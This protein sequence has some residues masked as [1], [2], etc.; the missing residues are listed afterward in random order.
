MRSVCIDIFSCSGVV[1]YFYFL[2]SVHVLP[3]T[4]LLGSLLAF[5]SADVR[6]D[7]LRHNAVDTVSGDA[8]ICTTGVMLSFYCCC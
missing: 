8:V 7:T 3:F 6:T 1:L 4:M 2:L 5:F